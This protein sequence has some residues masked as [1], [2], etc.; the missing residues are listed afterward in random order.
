MKRW[1]A[2][3]AAI[4]PVLGFQAGRAD[5]SGKWSL[6]LQQSSHLSAAFKNVTSYVMDVTN[7]NDSMVI[8]TWMKGSGQEV[9]FPPTVY[10]FDSSEVFREDTLRGTKRWIRA[11]WAPGRKL[12][13]YNRVIQT[14]GT[15]VQQYTQTDVW[16]AKDRDT[17]FLSTKRRFVRNDSTAQEQRIFR[18]V[19]K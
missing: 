13:V 12:T 14:R 5:F 8:S 19:A 15:T 3:I 4:L 16:E 9:T 7:G 6:D 17:L 11:W 2:I 18:R 1:I 10:R